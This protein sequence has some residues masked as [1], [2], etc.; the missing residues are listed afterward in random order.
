M[1]FSPHDILEADRLH[2]FF[3]LAIQGQLLIPVLLI[4]RVVTGILV[5]ELGQTWLGL[6]TDLAVTNFSTAADAIFCVFFLSE[7]FGSDG[8]VD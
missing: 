7:A 2:L 4:V 6:A 8:G 1:L 3:T 5:W